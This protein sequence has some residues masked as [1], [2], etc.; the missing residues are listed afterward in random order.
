M[1]NPIKPN[2]WDDLTVRIT[3]SIAMVAIGAVGV[4][5]GGIWFQMMVVFVAAIM[6]WELWKMIAP[7]RDTAAALLAA[8]T[9]AILSAM[10][11]DAGSPWFLFLVVPISG[12]L[13]LKKL[14]FT[15]LMYALMTLVASYALVQFRDDFGALWIIWLLLVVI[16]SDV[17]GYFAGRTFGGPKFWPAIS[18]KKT[19]SGTAA[20]WI[21]AGGIGMI[22]AI[23]TDAGMIL[24]PLSMLLSF[25]GQMGDIAESAIKRRT[26]IKD[27]STLI[28]GHGGVLDRFDALLGV[29]FVMFIAV[30]IMNL[31]GVAF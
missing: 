12:A 15:F 26:G 5:A 23:S 4:V 24:V 13:V 8:A 11:T 27:S 2:N 19:W 29:A 18:P 25:A 31:S 1:A 21:G 14:R 10:L 17:L 30:N 22:F 28:P 6:I 9:T 20:G 16:A 7:H 3:S